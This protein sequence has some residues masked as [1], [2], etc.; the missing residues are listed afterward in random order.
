M[1]R[2]SVLLLPVWLSLG[3]AWV[4]PFLVAPHTY[5]VP[6]FYSEFAAAVCWTVLAAVT[7][8]LTWG[9]PTGLPRIALAP[10][11]LAVALIVQ[12][13]IA[14]PLNPFFSFGAIVALLA[15]AIIC[16][17]GAR[18]RELPGAVTVVAVAVIVGGLL[19]VAIELLQ[20]FRVPDLPATFFSIT[21]L[22]A[23]RR[24]WGNLNQP[25]H[26]GTYLAFGLAACL[27]LAHQYR[28]WLVPLWIAMLA[29][30]LGM[31]LT[32]SRGTWIHL[33][34]VGG[35]A[36]VVLTA[37]M[38][39]R[40]WATKLFALV[41]P[42][43][44]L[45]L[46]Y[47]IWN[48]VIALAN[49]VWALDLPGSMGERL[50]Q[51]VGLR[52]L[53]WNHAWHMFRAHPWLGGGWGDYAWNQF[54]Q[55]DTLGHVE[56]SMNAHNIVLDLL[57][58][59]GV[60]GLLA[61]LAPL[62][63]WAFDLRK[64]LCRPEVAFLSA[65]VAVLM[66][67]SLLEYPL[68]Y[69]FFLFPFA[70]T[71]G[72]LDSKMLRAPSATGAWMLSGTVALCGAVLA[73]RLWMDYAIVE[74]VYLTQGGAAKALNE[75][76][77]GGAMLLRPYATLAVAMNAPVNREMAPIAMELERTAAQF[78]PAPATVQRF[79]LALAFEGKNEAAVTQ[80]RRLYNHYW[81]D[82]PAQTFTLR[83]ACQRDADAL[84]TFCSRLRSEGLLASTD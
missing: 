46:A 33:A 83:Q 26:V 18:C 64:R 48:C 8:G 84:R 54:V 32:F 7:L 9:Q 25:N 66:V 41:G 70:F 65:I 31:A 55:T 40:S 34:V 1:R 75:H 67:H 77:D 50:H 22:G 71:L 39:Q 61:V 56:M 27:Y 59:I 29:L 45:V 51:G 28:C 10:L 69:I 79:A 74:R 36:G 38:R 76:Q 63:W 17:L 49:G 44:G 82:F 43:L 73:V 37:E 30:L 58:K 80:V 68:H 72:Y 42:L 52:S 3:A 4:I 47:Q 6:T 2:F 21:P 15:A 16:G 20:L 78:Y 23:G 53:L 14:P 11:A 62:T 24:M 13:A 12:L 81:T 5:P 60:V 35:L 19:T 57:A